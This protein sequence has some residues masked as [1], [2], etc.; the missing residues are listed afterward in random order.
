MIEEFYSDLWICEL[1]V[2]ASEEA[3]GD[4]F[5]L[6][7]NRKAGNEAAVIARDLG[8]EFFKEE[9]VERFESSVDKHKDIAGNL[10]DGAGELRFS[11]GGG[12]R[13]EAFQMVDGATDKLIDAGL[14]FA[15]GE[16]YDSGLKDAIF[17]PEED[18]DFKVAG[19]WISNAQR[20]MEKSGGDRGAFLSSLNVILEH[21]GPSRYRIGL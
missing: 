16:L 8:Q 11:A 15:G 2:G 17:G 13:V 20:S 7:I 21:P 10:A 9:M 1:A 5:V 4:G 19:N 6:R 12:V 18:S 3:G 14:P